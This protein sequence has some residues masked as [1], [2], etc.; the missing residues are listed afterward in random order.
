MR[1]DADIQRE[2]ESALRGPGQGAPL[3]VAVHEG[4]VRLAGVVGSYCDKFGLEALVRGIA[5]VENV[6][7]ELEVSLPLAGHPCDED[8][9]CAVLRALQTE[10]PEI[11]DT[12][13]ARVCR[14]EVTL[15]G[16]VEWPFLRE[17]AESAVRRLGFVS[18]VHNAITLAESALTRE[19]TR[20]IAEA[21]A[22]CA[23]AEP[24][25][26]SVAT[27]GSEATLRGQVSSVF[28]RLLAEQSAWAVPG[29]RAVRNELT[30]RGS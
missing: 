7:N 8:I 22:R 28:E 30:L 11:S 23:H 20:Q 4:V 1:S 15:E 12:L 9:H 2:A 13:R 18:T 14:G 24:R 29:I 27:H 17:R 26:I 25:Q 10:V 5:G 16:R 3:D 21:F 6:V 19:V